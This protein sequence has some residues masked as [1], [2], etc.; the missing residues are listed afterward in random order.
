MYECYIKNYDC[1]TPVA[2]AA[3]LNNFATNTFLSKIS[4]LAYQGDNSV[5]EQ[6]EVWEMIMRNHN[7][8][9]CKVPDILSNYVHYTKSV[10]YVILCP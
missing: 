6:Q 2:V 5:R 3:M 7:K 1:P 10:K 9:L 8:C 4:A